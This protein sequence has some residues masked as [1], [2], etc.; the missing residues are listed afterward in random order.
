MKFEAGLGNVSLLNL[1]KATLEDIENPSMSIQRAMAIPGFGLTYGSKLLR[2]LRPDLHASLDRRIR[3]ALLKE[4]LLDK[5]HDG[6]APS[7]IRGYVAFIAFLNKLIVELDYRGIGRPECN[8][9]LGH[10]K[11]WRVADVE[12]ALFA[13]A[14]RNATKSGERA[15]KTG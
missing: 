1:I 6:K 9:P 3:A 2:F 11:G 13:W 14:G 5:I 12:M 7:M 4:E 15:E 8:L 10:R